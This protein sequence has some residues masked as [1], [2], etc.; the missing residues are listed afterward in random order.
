M[1][2]NCG[3]KRSGGNGMG[4]IVLRQHESD[5]SWKQ[6]LAHGNEI[7][8]LICTL[9]LVI[10]KVG[11]EAALIL[12]VKLAPKSE[13]DTQNGEC[14]QFQV[15]QRTEIGRNRKEIGNEKSYRQIREASRE[16]G[17]H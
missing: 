8:L 1:E 15:R 2:A 10:V 13:E 12:V 14:P 16:K 4:N 9:F 5:L 11:I 17:G 7:A 6:T 3:R